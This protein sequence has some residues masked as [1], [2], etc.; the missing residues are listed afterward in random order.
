MIRKEKKKKNDEQIIITIN[1]STNQSKQK[2]KQKRKRKKEK[3][4]G[5]KL[6]FKLQLQSLILL[7]NKPTRLHKQ[8]HIDD[9]SQ[10]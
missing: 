7:T 5:K 6:F 1:Q 3:E 4:Q 2:Q 9:N 8:T 10:P